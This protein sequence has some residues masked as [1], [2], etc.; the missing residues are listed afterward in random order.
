MKNYT[1]KSWLLPVA[2]GL[3]S[4]AGCGGGGTS[5]SSGTIADKVPSAKTKADVAS[6][7]AAY[8]QGV[9]SYSF[10]SY[11]P[12]MKTLGTVFFDNGL[13]LY[14][15]IR[16]GAS[17]LFEG[18]YQD[19][20]LSLPAG[21]LN[22]NTFDVTH[23]QS[24]DITVTQGLYAGLTGTYTSAR[25]TS[26]QSGNINFNM[27]GVADTVCQFVVQFDSNGNMYG[28]ATTAVAMQTGSSQTEQVTYNA[29][30]TTLIAGS[31]ANKCKSSLKFTKTLSGGGTIS[32]TDPGLPAKLT[33]NSAGSGQITY[34]DGST[35]AFTNWKLAN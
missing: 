2:V 3:I 13:G 21:N 18:L 11:G 19:Q 34:A 16:L 9:V 32:G 35:A 6:H 31:D 28:T 10:L 23:S 4:L 26:G 22:Y 7:L 14:A 17:V 12:K 8:S 29:D 1:R 5:G 20:E 24:G 30:G 25:Q 33:W 15:K 27:P